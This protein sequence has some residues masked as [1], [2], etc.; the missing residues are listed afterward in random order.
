M[1]RAARH[2]Q[3]RVHD[4]A[5]Q[6]LHAK[7]GARKG[8]CK[9][10]AEQCRRRSP[11][12]PLARVATC[13]TAGRGCGGRGRGGGSRRH[14]S[15]RH[16]SGHPPQHHAGEQD[17]GG[18]APVDAGGKHDRHLPHL[19][20]RRTGAIPARGGRRGGGGGRCSGERG[21]R[22]G[23][24]GLAGRARQACS[25]RERLGRGEGREA[26][27]H[28][29]GEGAD[30]VG[31]RGEGDAEVEEEGEADAGHGRAS[32]A[33]AHRRGEQGEAEDRLAERDS[34]GCGGYQRREQRE[35]EGVR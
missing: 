24:D 17:K 3:V 11:P 14:P 7:D 15:R 1:V 22:R 25:T 23:R 10:D 16:P 21:E 29:H 2:A 4:R 35:R 8:V 30:V 32:A 31:R 28:Q 13:A 34:A 19:A 18:D 9:R 27:R 6:I 12:E 26:A 5:A 33:H 20:R